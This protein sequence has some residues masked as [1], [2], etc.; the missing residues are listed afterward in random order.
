MAGTTCIPLLPAPITATRLSCYSWSAGSHKSNTQ[1]HCWVKVIIPISCMQKFAFEVVQTRNIRPFPFIQQTGTS[2][3]YIGLVFHN[4]GLGKVR[5]Q[6][7]DH[8][9]VPRLIP[10]SLR[11]FVVESDVFPN[12]IL[13]CDSFPILED[14]CR[15]RVELRPV[16]PRLIAQLVYM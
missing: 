5:P 6:Q 9:L 16:G 3:E 1:T 8:P 4:N 14:L 10:C 11:A 12:T 15:A 2:D 13:V 7:F